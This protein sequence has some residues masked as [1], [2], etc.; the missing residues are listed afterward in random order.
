LKRLA[1]FPLGRALVREFGGLHVGQNGPGENC[2]T[3]DIRFHRS[4]TAAHRESILD[5]ESTGE[6]FFPLAEAQL[7]Y[8][9][10]FINARGRLLTYGVPD[11]SLYVAG[12][13]FAA[14]IERLLLGRS[15][16]D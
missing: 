2:A 4:P 8:L 13:T 16:F 7:G 9:E 5:L 10:L 1:S 12:E 3:S 11:G 14:G 6:D 15:W